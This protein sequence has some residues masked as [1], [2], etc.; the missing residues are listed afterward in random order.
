MPKLIVRSALWNGV[1]V[2]LIVSLVACSNAPEDA[3][4][5]QADGCPGRHGNSCTPG[6]CCT[7]SYC[8]ATGHIDVRRLNRPQFQL[9]CRHCRYC[10]TVVADTPT[11]VPT[12]PEAERLSAIGLELLRDLT[13]DYS[14][15]ESGTDGELRRRGV[16]W[17]I[18]G[19]YGL[20]CRVPARGG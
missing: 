6:Y 15:R 8:C 9:H 7:P 20:C 1:A 12:N 11:P 17:Q 4:A 18:P 3:P 16:H 19:G 10:R 14:P 2:A 13:A 5:A